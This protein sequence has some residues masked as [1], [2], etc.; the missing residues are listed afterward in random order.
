MK[1]EPDL[2]RISEAEKVEIKKQID[3][4]QCVRKQPD[5]PRQTVRKSFAQDVR[6]RFVGKP[7]GFGE[8]SGLRD[9][10]SYRIYP[11]SGGRADWVNWFSDSLLHH[12][13]F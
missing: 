13:W 10:N 5:A 4:F 7:I 1:N 3:T 2:S 8:R 9:P 12:L 6:H 11:Q